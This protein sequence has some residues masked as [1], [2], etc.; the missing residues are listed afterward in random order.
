MATWAAS[1]SVT[2]GKQLQRV[3]QQATPQAKTGWLYKEPSTKE[4]T[5]GR[6]AFLGLSTN[7]GWKH[8]FF[9]LEYNAESQASN[10]S[11][12]DKAWVNGKP[13]NGSR[14]GAMPLTRDCHLRDVRHARSKAEAWVL[15]DGIPLNGKDYSYK[16]VLAPSDAETGA[17]EAELWRKALQEHID[18]NTISPHQAS[19]SGIPDDVLPRSLR[20]KPSRAFI[21]YRQAADPDLAERIVDKLGA[22]FPHVQTWWDKKDL[23]KGEDFIANFSKA[24]LDSNI[25][26]PIISKASLK[27]FAG[28]DEESTVD[29]VFLEMRLAVELK[30]RGDIMS[31]FPILVG[32]VLMRFKLTHAIH[33][34]DRHVVRLLNPQLSMVGETQNYESFYKPEHNGKPPCKDVAVRLVEDKVREI[35]A[36]NFKDSTKMEASG[37]VA[38]VLKDILTHNG[39]CLKPDDRIPARD[40][41]QQACVCIKDE[42]DRIDRSAEESFSE[43]TEGMKA[44]CNSK[45]STD[46][47]SSSLVASVSLGGAVPQPPPASPSLLPEV[48]TAPA[49]KPEMPFLDKVKLI[50]E[51]LGI[52]TGPPKGVLAEANEQ[53]GLTTEGALPKQAD[54]LLTA[55]GLP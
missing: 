29:N 33:N 17:E 31:I 19:N 30:E 5:K 9:V 12:Y 43:A 20:Q 21:S 10:L 11:Y 45:P 52:P 40:F 46:S 2:K 25:Y 47:V 27:D 53:M 36:R 1:F 49:I 4:G 26:V 32:E 15:V 37:E 28:L 55:L 38:G 34:S 23:P 54:A 44:S 42:F 6:D 7:G 24:L 39:H 50:Q 48:A 13:I 51:S 41:I 8:R 14:R 16:L 3:K 22:N 18:H 35:L